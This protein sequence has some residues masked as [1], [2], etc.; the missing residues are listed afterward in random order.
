MRFAVAHKA[1]TYMMVAFAYAAMVTGGG[2]QPVIALSGLVGLIASWWWEPP[3]ISFERWTWMWTIASVFALV[4]SVLT[5]VVTGDFLGVGAQFLIWLVVAKSYNRRAAR[6]WQQ[7]YL[8]AF[9]MLVAGSVLNADLTYGICFLGFV[10]STTWAMTLFHLRREM[11]DNFLVKHTSATRAADRVEVRRILDSKRIVG[12]RF[13]LGTGALSFGAFVMASVVFLA[14]PRVGFG[15]FVKNQHGL[16]MAGFNDGVKLGGHG[17]IKNDPTVV[18]RVEIDPRFGGRDKAEIHWRGVAFDK[19]EHGR[20]SRSKIAPHTSDFRS[21]P[22]PGIER[23]HIR[24]KDNEGFDADLAVKQE[25]WLDPFDTDVLFGASMPRAYELSEVIRRRPKD[26]RN[27]EFRIDHGTTLHYTVWSELFPPSPQALRASHGDVPIQFA[28]YY[29]VPPE[30]T[31]ETR[32]LA[33]QITAGLDNN[34]DKAKAIERWLETNLSYTLELADPGKAEPIHFFLIQRKKGHCE[35]FASAFVVLARL[36]NIPTRQVNG[37]LG[38]EWNEYKGY[39]AVRAGDAHS[40]AEVYF[41]GQGWVTFDATPAAEGGELGRGGTGFRAKMARF[42]DTLRFQWSKWVIEYDLSS[43]MQL[44]KDVGSTLKGAAIAVRDALK[45]VLQLWPALL[46]LIG[47]AIGWTLW[48]RRR[49]EQILPGAIRVVRP[50]RSTVAEVY[51]GVIKQL[52]KHGTRKQPGQTPRELASSLAGKPAG[53]ELAELTEL[54]Y[55]AEWG[56]RRD[57]AAETRASELA[58][59]IRDALR[60][61]PQR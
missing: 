37:F 13:F 42:V 54:Y 33:V 52:A 46:A 7:I 60:S 28:P 15:F 3:N 57:P 41:P 20:W 10:I 19:Y 22:R 6:D 35:Y 55:A 36:A 30:I 23:H 56:A 24:L 38:G 50:P 31:A 51:D 34:Y 58:M 14:I 49:V 53:T 61:A 9:L 17:V 25:I 18:M 2:I 29:Q 12:R 43:Q 44:F 11:E 40:W 4:Y 39:V 45:W 27:D 16:S 48:R 5:A 1:A 8:L 47:G 32:A 26:L 59:Q 21:T